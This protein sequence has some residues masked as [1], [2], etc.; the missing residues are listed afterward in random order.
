[1]PKP[2]YEAFSRTAALYDV[3]NP[4]LKIPAVPN[5]TVT[6]SLLEFRAYIVPGDP[7]IGMTY[8]VYDA[9]NQLVAVAQP[10][11]LL[12][13]F[14]NITVSLQFTPL[15]KTVYTVTFDVNDIH[16]NTTQRVAH[17]VVS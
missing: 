5:P 2:S 11:A 12:D 8:R 1:V 17:L 7:P 10:T 13:L 4:V 9:A 15:P 6:L 3:G 14:G 16:G